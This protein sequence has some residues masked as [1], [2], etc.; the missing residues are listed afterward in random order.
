M[1]PRARTLREWARYS[2]RN[3]DR[4]NGEKMW[5]EAQ[6]LFV[7]LGAQKEVERMQDLPQ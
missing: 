6:G 2:L 3:G 7:T 1:E 5:R 4:E